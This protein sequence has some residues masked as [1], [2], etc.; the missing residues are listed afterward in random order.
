MRTSKVKPK[1]KFIYKP[2]VIEASFLR[3]GQID[4]HTHCKLVREQ[5]ILDS[6]PNYGCGCLYRCNHNGMYT[7]RNSHK[8]TN[9]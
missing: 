7:S 9:K 1:K 3:K 8:Q 6:Y 2:T 5:R 4:K